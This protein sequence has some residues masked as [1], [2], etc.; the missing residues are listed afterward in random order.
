[1]QIIPFLLMKLYSVFL[2]SFLSLITTSFNSTPE[3]ENLQIPPDSLKTI[4]LTFVGDLMCHVPQIDYA[5]KGA[6]TFDF[7]PVYRMV[8]EH[9]SSS[10]FTL[11]NLETVTAGKKSKYSG[12]PLFNSPDAFISALSSAGFDFVFTSNNHSLDRGAQGVIRTIN[13]LDSHRI[14]HTGTFLDQYDRDSIK[15]VNISGIETVLLSYSYDTNGN[16]VPKG[17]SYL[18]NLIDTTLIKKDISK[19]K[20]FNPDLIIVYFHFGDEYKR[21]PSAFQ[22]LIVSKTAEYGADLIIGSHPHVVQPITRIKGSHN[23]DTVL[24]FYS[25]G[26]FISNQRDRYR[27][28][29]VILNVEITKNFTRDSVFLSG[30]DFIPTWVFKG[31]SDLGREFIIFLEDST[32][33]LPSYLSAEDIQ[34]M[35]QSFKDTREIFKIIR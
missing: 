29:G 33:P 16:P 30:Y 25:L 5:R 2:V 26:N 27:D 18:I 32:R 28:G 6:D 10:D 17:R 34:R 35:K 4:T 12:Y 15:I 11:G 13:I 23:I 8:K 31:S 1:M 22:K 20:L 24:T 14:A 7:S 19:A 21:D 3:L 9:L